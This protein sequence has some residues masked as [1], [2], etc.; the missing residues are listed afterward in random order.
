MRPLPGLQHDVLL[1][2]LTTIRVGGPARYYLRAENREH[3]EEGVAWAGEHEIPLFVLGGGSNI[4]VAD[5]GFPGLVL[6]LALRGFTVLRNG[7]AH[8][9]AAAGESW[10]ALVAAAVERGWAGLECLSGIPGFVGAAPIQ[11][12]GAYGQDVSETIL[13]V[14]VVD[15]ADGRSLTLSNEDCRFAYRHSRF[16]G[17]DRGR[18]LI[19]GVTFSLRPGGAPALRYPEL[20]QHLFMRGITSP[21]LKDVRASVLDIRRRK[22]M[23]VD[24]L[25][26]HSVSVGSFF[27]N[28]VV[29]PT[30]EAEVREVLT[31]R[32]ESALADTMPAFLARDRQVKLSAA[33]L[34]E[35]AGLGRGY[36]RG[37]VGISVNHTLAIVN[38]GGGTAREIL[39]L[40]HEIG[41]RV[42]DSFG[43]A[44][45]PEP[46]F[47][48]LSF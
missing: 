47:V 35:R 18:Y 21:T 20:E 33:W 48:N 13:R 43:I 42:L 31:R 41:Q 10:D 39:D 23:V 25:D 37:N 12:V 24:P 1:A 8:L 34:I 15:L 2:P 16:K 44:L 9:G 11:N 40:A 28:P 32:G 36:R 3:I 17:D 26:P 19:L 29:S 4:V 5:E 6:H 45:V 30:K 38:Y 27:V 22:S 46:V 7:H 14:E